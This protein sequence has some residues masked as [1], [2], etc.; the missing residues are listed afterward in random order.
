MEKTLADKI[1][2]RA[3][4]KNKILES[5]KN[6]ELKDELDDA[7]K[8]D[9][10]LSTDVPKENPVIVKEGV[11]GPKEQLKEKVDS[12]ILS[13]KKA[14]EELSK[15]EG[16]AKKNIAI[17]VDRLTTNLKTLRKMYKEKFG[18]SLDGET[19]D[20]M[21]EGNQ[22]S[23]MLS[24]KIADI[25]EKKTALHDKIS[26]LVDKKKNVS[27]DKKYDSIEKELEGLYAQSKKMSDEI[28]KLHNQKSKARKSESLEDTAN[29]KL[30]SAL[31][32]LDKKPVA[33][34]AEM[35]KQLFNKLSDV[36]SD[37]SAGASILREFS[38]DAFDIVKGEVEDE[39]EA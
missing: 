25:K 24:K 2:E 26:K 34:Q 28:E 29:A 33:K 9:E 35:Y 14:K 18:E 7:G 39:I 38:A 16:D 20:E 11:F 1:L 22:E 37:L 31:A 13:L 27:D 30:L 36:V 6:E 12:A 21:E 23:R 8:K 5:K 32:K 4:K 10:L 15:A 3:E 17:K 19:E